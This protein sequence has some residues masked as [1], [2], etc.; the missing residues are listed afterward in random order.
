MNN[1]IK[2]AV[3]AMGGENSPTKVIKGIEIHNYNSKNIF[4][5]I[6]GDVNLIKPIINKTKISENNFELIHTDNNI[7]DD[8][9]RLTAANKGKNTS[10]WLSIESL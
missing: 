9:S 7:K 6:F 10:M 5:N 4:Y 8:D 2:I 3:D 1:P